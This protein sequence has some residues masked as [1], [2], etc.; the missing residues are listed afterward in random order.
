[1]EDK[2]ILQIIEV[3]TK[4]SEK[5]FNIKNSYEKSIRLYGQG[6]GIT[7]SIK[8]TLQKLENNI[9]N[10]KRYT[11][12]LIE[13]KGNLEK[14]LKE[15]KEKTKQLKKEGREVLALINE[16]DKSKGYQIK[17]DRI[18]KVKQLAEEVLE[19]NEIIEQKN[20]LLLQIK[21]TLKILGY[22]EL[23]K[24]NIDKKIEKNKKTK[25]EKMDNLKE[26]KEKLL[27]ENN[28]YKEKIEQHKKEK[29]ELTNNGMDNLINYELEAVKKQNN[30]L[31]RIDELKK[32]IKDYEDKILINDK[33]IRKIDIEIKNMKNK[34]VD[35][36]VQ[37]LQQNNKNE[38][39]FKQVANVNGKTV[40]IAKA[41]NRY[42]DVN[43]MVRYI[44]KIEEDI[45]LLDFYKDIYVSGKQ[46]D[47]SKIYKEKE[48]KKATEKLF[49]PDR[50]NQL[51][52]EAIEHK[53]DRI[54]LGEINELG[55]GYYQNYRYK[56]EKLNNIY[57]T[58]ILND[59]KNIQY[60]RNG[61]IEQIK[62]DS[63]DFTIQYKLASIGYYN[64]QLENIKPKCLKEAK[65]EKENKLNEPKIVIEEP[66]TFKE[67]KKNEI[68]VFINN[69]EPVSELKKENKFSKIKGRFKDFRKKIHEAFFNLKSYEGIKLIP[70]QIKQKNINLG[71]N[72]SWIPRFDD[73]DGHIET[74]ALDCIK[75]MEEVANKILTR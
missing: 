41:H 29:K 65:E 63:K 18:K 51:E 31:R 56:G 9:N 53:T 60:K 74:T 64:S 37:N 61:I 4:E 75:R 68:E 6:S 17:Q 66:Q 44:L 12:R 5:R 54:Y 73:R 42:Q 67:N 35:K 45:N 1:M 25:S 55:N 16:D 71:N 43:N 34:N 28:K 30:I 52:K 72:K 49:N 27:Q 14:E 2:S 69:E 15:L 70:K 32:Y 24:A 20:K 13:E 8:P 47:F 48:Y 26:E 3:I 62:K 46:I 22:K 19:N 50:I 58:F 40:K 36:V 23:E 10:F 38:Y 33:T 21:G 39:E 57:N 59:Y 7:K 11:K